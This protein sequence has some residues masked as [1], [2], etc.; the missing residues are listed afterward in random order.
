[1]LPLLLSVPATPLV[2]TP[3]APPEIEPPEL[4]VML[5]PPAK[6]TPAPLA[7]T[8]LMLPLLVSVPAPPV[9]A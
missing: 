5:P 1:M 6:S 7:P 8:A 3:N 4:F 9:P 2:K